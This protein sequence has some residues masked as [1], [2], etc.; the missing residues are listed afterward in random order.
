MDF[1]PKMRGLGGSSF[2]LT[3]WVSFTSMTAKSPMGLTAPKNILFGIV[4]TCKPSKLCIGFS[5]SYNNPSIQSEIGF[6]AP[7]S[8]ATSITVF[9]SVAYVVPSLNA[10]RFGK[11]AA[12]AMSWKS[13]SS[14]TAKSCA[15]VPLPP[16]PVIVTAAPQRVA[17]W[18]RLVTQIYGWGSGDISPPFCFIAAPSTFRATQASD[19]TNWRF[20]LS[21]RLQSWC[22]GKRRALVV[23]IFDTVADFHETAYPHNRVEIPALFVDR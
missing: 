19:L 8:G 15:S 13:I 6:G 4:A 1:C 22:T 18:S 20:F 2:V 3:Q 23:H 9:G 21:P 17:I 16:A 7:V 5:F 14:V 10:G 11:T 12:P